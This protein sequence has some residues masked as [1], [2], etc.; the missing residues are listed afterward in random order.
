M[1]CYHGSD[2][3]VRNPM[4]IP[5]KRPL[6]FGEGFYVTS[7]KEQSL[8]WASKVAFRYKSTNYFVSEYDFNIEKAKEELKV[9]TFD[10]ANL[11]WLNFVCSNRMN[12]YSEPYDIVIGPVA[13]DTVYSVI[14]KY[15]EGD[16]EPDVAIKK[17]KTEKLFDQILFHTAKSLNYLQFVKSEVYKNE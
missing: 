13:D 17:L 4:V 9:I 11:E 7:S 5:S 15:E 1:I 6:D 10:E 2:V 12:D 8:R 14:V 3:E 16:I